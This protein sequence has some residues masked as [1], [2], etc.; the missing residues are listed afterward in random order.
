MDQQPILTL[1]TIAPV[2]PQIAIEVEVEGVRKTLFHDLAL[3]EDFGLREL[4]EMKRFTD[5]VYK[6][7]SAIE[8]ASE[9]DI[10]KVEADI[11]IF[12]KRIVKGIEDSTLAKLSRSAKTAIMLAFNKAAPVTPPAAAKAETPAETPASTTGESPAPDSSDSTEGIPSAGLTS[13]SESSAP[14]S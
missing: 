7:T 8:S 2:H 12:I 3:M 4:A 10:A 6:V 9:Q 5:S 14:T 1:S 13:P 11:D